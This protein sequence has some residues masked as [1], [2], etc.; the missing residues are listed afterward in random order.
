M[1]LTDEVD[2]LHQLMC[3]LEKKQKNQLIQL[4]ND[5]NFYDGM[6][7]MVM[8]MLMNHLILHEQK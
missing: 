8:S 5:M 3:Y 6:K 1:I 2:Q 4:K 7:K